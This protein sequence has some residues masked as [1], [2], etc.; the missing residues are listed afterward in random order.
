MA[1]LEG[2][3]AGKPRLPDSGLADDGDDAA[4]VRLQRSGQPGQLLIPADERGVEP[5]RLAHERL[6]AFVERDSG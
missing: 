3:L 4:G 1:G 5:P 2:D 6:R